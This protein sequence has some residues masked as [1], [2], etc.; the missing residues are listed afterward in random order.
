MLASLCNKLTGGQ[1]IDKKSMTKHDGNTD[2]YELNIAPLT[3][4]NPVF[5]NMK[6]NADKGINQFPERFFLK[7]SNSSIFNRLII[8]SVIT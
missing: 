3:V 4:G 7:S 8:Y 6:K 5:N 2:I 1:I